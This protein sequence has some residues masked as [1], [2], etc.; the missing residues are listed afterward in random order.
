MSIT[1]DSS[2]YLTI[3]TSRPSDRRMV[4]TISV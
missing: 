3:S 4:N 2:G 1:C